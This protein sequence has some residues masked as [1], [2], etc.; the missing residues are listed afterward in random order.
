MTSP[1]QK[2]Y[3]NPR[4]R[5]R[6]KQHL[7]QHPLCTY[8]LQEG[9][10]TQAKVAD[11]IV[12]H[13]GDARLFFYGD[14]QSLCW[15]HHR[16]T[17]QQQEKIG[18]SKDIG[19]DGW[20]I[21]PNHPANQPS[22]KR[23]YSIPFG[24]KPSAIPVTLVCGPPAAGKT[25]WVNSRLTSADIVVCLDECRLSVGGTPWDQDR[26]ILRQALRHRDQL[27][28]TLAHK[29]GC[30]GIAYV[31]ISAPTEGERAAWGKVLGITTPPYH[32]QVVLMAT[33]AETCI[34]RLKADPRRR[35][36]LQHQILAVLE[37]H[38]L[39]KARQTTSML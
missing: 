8:C 10:V 38:R 7:R 16:S 28:H 3:D 25:T 5:K 14:L 1:W 15:P 35:H 2:L 39:Y 24:L 33:P 36:V 31:I 20:P 32:G 9:Q 6:S 11:H 22:T 30:G 29:Q 19:L 26:G 23:Q 17:K 12:P 13:H 37:W 34:A 21:D 27:L 4:W 18:F